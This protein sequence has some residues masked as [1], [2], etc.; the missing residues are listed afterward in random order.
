MPSGGEREGRVLVSHQQQVRLDAKIPAQHADRKLVQPGRVPAREQD[1]EPR[2]D[3]CEHPSDV[4]EH[5]HDHVRE[6]IEDPEP[7][8]HAIAITGGPADLERGRVG[9]FPER[10][11]LVA[12]EHEIRHRPGAPT[13]VEGGE[14]PEA[15]RMGSREDDREPRDHCHDTR[16]RAQDATARR[17]PEAQARAPGQQHVRDRENDPKAGRQAVPVRELGFDVEGHRVG[18]P[19]GP[20]H[21]VAHRSPSS[22]EASTTPR[23]KRVQ[24]GP[25]LEY[26]QAGSRSATCPEQLVE[27]RAEAG[28]QMCPTSRARCGAL[29]LHRTA[30]ERR[31]G[32]RTERRAR[33]RANDRRAGTEPAIGALHGRI[34]PRQHRPDVPN[35]DTANIARRGT[36]ASDQLLMA[37]TTRSAYTAAPAGFTWT[38]SAA[39]HSGCPHEVACQS[40]ST[41]FDFQRWT[42]SAIA[43]FTGSCHQ[44]GSHTLTNAT[45]RALARDCITASNCTA[46]NGPFVPKPTTT[47]TGSRPASAS[48]VRSR[49]ALKNWRLT[50][51]STAM[52]WA[53]SCARTSTITESPNA[54]VLP[55]GGAVGG[56]AVAAVVV[57]GTEVDVVDVLV[58]V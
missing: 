18:G 14:V 41:A 43:V 21:G 5:E 53:S 33:T 11:V 46:L 19:R 13:E 57:A 58:V 44:R 20:G 32:A 48:I 4:E 10:R 1:G 22:P 39:N 15:A 54:S 50:D 55:G 7:D 25:L 51:A 47:T 16:H 36:N 34:S 29:T 45:R 35:R 31:V 27:H 42:P 28:H 9:S 26:S 2:H 12:Q 38:R 24:R 3:R 52:P 40:T 23:P 6:G 30:P 49:A 17:P 8:R 56:T 37:R